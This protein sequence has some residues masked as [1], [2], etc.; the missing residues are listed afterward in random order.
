MSADG[1]RVVAEEIITTINDD[2]LML[3][4]T[5]LKY[6]ITKHLSCNLVQSSDVNDKFGL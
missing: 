3:T 4:M 1:E 5:I 2:V 6:E